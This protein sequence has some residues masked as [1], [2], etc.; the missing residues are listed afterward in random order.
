MECDL[1]QMLHLLHG[2]VRRLDRH[3][4]LLDRASRELFGVPCTPEAEALERRVLAVAGREAGGT[5]AFVRLE[6][7]AEGRERLL[8]AG[9]SY[10]AGY[11][12]RSL[13]YRGVTV[14][15]EPPLNGYPTLAR[16][17]AAA[18]AR[19]MAACAGGEVGVLC[20]PDGSYHT[21]EASPLAVVEGYTVVVPP[22]GSCVTLPSGAGG[23]DRRFGALRSVEYGLLTE[24]VRAAGLPLEERP[25]GP[26]ECGRFDEL[27]WL[28]H[29]GITALS[30]LDGRPLMTLVAE[31]VA[32]ALENL[33]AN[34]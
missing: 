33:F 22:E 2:R 9:V 12:L 30:H 8:A 1:Y 13:Q 5:S 17:A 24:A 7:T 16:E 23:A 19:R 32:G 34:R 29:R 6:W 27:F 25:V 14:A 21:V 15:C 20:G 26:A 3:V 10:Y 11:A 4:A 28:D 31:R 18:A